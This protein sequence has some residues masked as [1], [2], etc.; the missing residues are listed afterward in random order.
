MKHLILGS[1]GQIGTALKKYL[2]SINEEVIEFDI[3]RSLDED[4]RYDS[5]N[6]EYKVRECDFVYFL[7]FDVG[8]AKYLDENQNKFGFIRNNMMIMSNTF[9]IL[10]HVKK[11]FIFA[12]SPN[13]PTEGYGMLKQLGERMTID[14]GG[15][16]TRFWNVYDEEDVN[17]RSHVIT[18]FINM[19]KNN[20]LIK[21][22]TDGYET[23]QFL[24]G[25]D[26]SKALY[27]ISQKYNILED[28]IQNITSFK[29][30]TIKQVANIVSEGFDYIPIIPG[31][32]KDGQ[33]YNRIEPN[34][35]DII[36]YWN[37]EIELKTGI[38]ILSNYVTSK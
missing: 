3:K 28:K 27:T 29:W 2:K 1:S 5:D 18:D 7:A 22:R 34:K 14:I 30:Y 32:V 16:V 36:K 37:P 31:T 19:A 10:D 35:T 4:L 17:E 8:G 33:N 9:M 12:S 23:R 24:H 13:Y 20:Q 21:M 11:P 6:L 26:C 38:K 25:L 15:I